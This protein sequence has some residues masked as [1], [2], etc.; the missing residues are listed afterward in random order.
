MGDRH[1]VPLSPCPFISHGLDTVLPANEHNDLYE[2]L[3]AILRWTVLRCL[4]DESFG[5]RFRDKDA[6]DAHWPLKP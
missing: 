5:D 1:H 3:E 2:K 6:V 4:R